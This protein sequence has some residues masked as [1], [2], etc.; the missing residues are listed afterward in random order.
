MTNIS[1]KW[2]NFG[3]ANPVE[4]GGIFVKQDSDNSN[5]FYI[6][7]N[8]PIDGE[9]N[10]QYLFDLYVDTSDDWIEK[11]SVMDYLGMTE[12]KFD[13]IQYAIGITEY[14]NYLNF[15]SRI[16]TDNVIEELQKFDI[17]VE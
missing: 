15:G 7:K 1:E 12:E 11:E 3:D 4:H 8:Q 17:H 5:A 14:Y 2:S 13:I 16:E 9:E 6:I 10:K